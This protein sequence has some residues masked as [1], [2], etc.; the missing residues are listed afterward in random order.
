M[1][2]TKGE[3]RRKKGKSNKKK[4]DM[5]NKLNTTGF[6]CFW[7]CLAISIYLDMFLHIIHIQPIV[8]HSNTFQRTLFEGDHD[9]PWHVTFGASMRIERPVLALNTFKKFFAFFSSCAAPIH[10]SF[11][12]A[13]AKAMTIRE[14]HMKSIR[15]QTTWRA[16]ENTPLVYTNPL[17][18]FVEVKSKY[19]QKLDYFFMCCRIQ[20]NSPS[21]SKIRVPACVMHL[22]R[23]LCQMQLRSPNLCNLTLSLT[24]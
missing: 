6:T 12:R 8:T 16:S 13:A 19:L 9:R 14:R 15:K 23:S 22:L 4:N 3:I 24:L 11:R 7:V 21:Y 2:P 1:R 17:L 18:L 10:H 5:K 20:Q